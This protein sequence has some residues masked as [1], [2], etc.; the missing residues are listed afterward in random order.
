MWGNEIGKKERYMLSR[1]I[2]IYSC[3]ELYGEWG[4]IVSNHAPE[5]APRN[6][7]LSF[8]PAAQSH[9]PNSTFVRSES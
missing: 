4:V 8:D 9:I 6:H 3:F 2:C 7:N 5:G 1:T